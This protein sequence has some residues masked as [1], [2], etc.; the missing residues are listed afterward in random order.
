MRMLWTFASKEKL[1][2]FV[3]TLDAHEIPYTVEAKGSNQYSILVDERVY[4]KA[5]KILLKYKERKTSADFM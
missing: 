5:R 2:K 4:P 3:V 1:D